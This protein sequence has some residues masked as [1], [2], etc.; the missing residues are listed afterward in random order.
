RCQRAGSQIVRLPRTICAATTTVIAS[1]TC[2]TPPVGTGRAG[3]NMS[4]MTVTAKLRSSKTLP[5]APSVLLPSL[6]SQPSSSS[7]NDVESGSTRLSSLRP[8]AHRRSRSA[9][10]DREDDARLRVLVVEP[11][12][13]RLAVSA[14]VLAGAADDRLLEGPRA[15]EEAERLLEAARAEV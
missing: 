10:L 3:R 8:G 9:R 6:R 5:S 13:R 11:G 12:T 4:R 15:G 14:L 1:N 7:L 2:V